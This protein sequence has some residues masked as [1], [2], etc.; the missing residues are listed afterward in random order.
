LGVPASEEGGNPLTD[1]AAVASVLALFRLADHPGDTLARYHVAN[2]PVGAAVKFTD[3]TDAAAASRLSHSFR[4]RLIDDGYGNT[5]AWLTPELQSAC[6]TRERRRLSQ[7]V[8]LAFRFDPDATLRASDFVRRVEVE[9]VED[10]TTA[11]IRVMT[12]HQA[13]GLEFDAVILPEL[14]EPLTRGSLKPF[15]YR[16]TPTD[17]VA[18]IFPY[19]PQHVRPLFDEVP[20]LSA[21]MAQA[22][23]AQLRDAL[24]AFY[25]A[26]TRARHAVHILVKPDGA[27]GMGK[28][29]TPARLLR[30]AI[31]A[32]DPA[33]EGDV[34]LAAGDPRWFEAHEGRHTEAERPREAG[35]QSI[36]GTPPVLL[37]KA[38]R[39]S[40]ALPRVR[41]SD[42]AG[43]PMVDLR[44]LLRLEFAGAERGTITHAWFERVGWIE[45]GLPSDD[46]LRIIAR[47]HGHLPDDDL[48]SL[49]SDFKAAAAVPEIARALSRSE[50]GEG[51][52]VEHETPFVY[53]DDD[54]LI[55]GVIDRLVLSYEQGVVTR[56]DI[57]D[58]KTDR[59]PAGDA[60]ELAK[61]S[62]YYAPQLEMYRCAVATLWNLPPHAVSAR[63][64]FLAPGRV[65]EAPATGP[66]R[67]VADTSS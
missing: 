46:E 50:Y 3:Y 10:P 42:L 36:S 66:L 59:I 34:L 49:I 55:E 41:P 57:L 67:A 45:D 37:R 4:Q 54:R 48:D 39:R 11:A 22:E 31:G 47:E 30:A 15:A 27:R 12:V 33:G 35:A 62:T 43:G 24:S 63:F 14:D 16:P 40:R 13:K 64:L 58:Y 9:R 20:E 7:L 60:A 6:D 26:M 65:V 44:S 38:S 52:T 2:T 51:A 23:A 21:A 25:V 32:G 5:L 56:A 1:S 8:E 53:R 19:V 28:S 61:R 18:R 29:K 17:P